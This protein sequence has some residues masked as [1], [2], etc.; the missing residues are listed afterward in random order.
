M[1]R[2]QPQRDLGRARLSAAR[3]RSIRGS[4]ADTAM[5]LPLEDS[6]LVPQHHDLDVLVRLGPKGRDKEPEEPADPKVKQ[7][8]NHGG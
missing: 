7:G 1:T 6:H 3:M 8:E 5:E 2:K 4:V